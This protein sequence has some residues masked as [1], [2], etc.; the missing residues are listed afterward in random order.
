M[1]IELP[2]PVAHL[3]R[4][5]KCFMSLDVKKDKAVYLEIGA[6]RGRSI[7]TISNI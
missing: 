5:L 3:E 4:T 2:L 6:H 7:G 1:K